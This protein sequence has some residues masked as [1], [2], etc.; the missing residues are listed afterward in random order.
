MPHAAVFIAALM[1]FGA[2]T[3]YG[4]AQGGG[5]SASAAAGAA[6]PTFVP[7]P[8]VS[9]DPV[10]PPLTVGA[11]P[12]GTPV[13][14]MATNRPT[15]SG[16]AASTAVPF[17]ASLFMGNFAALR[18]DGIN[19]AYLILPGDRVL[20]NA[21]GLVTINEV[22]I[23]DVQ[24]NIFI[25]GIGPVHLGGIP[26]GQLT[27]AVREGISRVYRNG[28]DVYTNLLSASPVAVYVTGRVVRP[29][30]YAGTPSDTPL[31]FLAQAG[32]IDAMTGSYRHV[33]V[34]RGE[35]VLADVDLYDFLISGRLP[36]VQFADGDVIL[37]DRRGPVVEV[38][39]HRDVA[40]LVEFPT[41][42]ITG[43][44]ILDVVVSAPR[45]AEITLQG[46][47]DGAQVM[48]AYPLEEFRTARLF[49]GD[50]VLL[51]NLRATGEILVHV[52]GEFHG[53][54]TL[55]V[56]RGARLLDVLAHVPTNSDLADIAGV[57]IRRT[58][59]AQ[60]Q[61][62]AL[63]D[64]LDR[65]ERSALLALSSSTGENAIRSREAEMVRAFVAT[66]R[67]VQPLGRVVASHEGLTRNVQLENEDVIVIPTRS[68]VV[69]VTGEVQVSQALAY[70]PGLTIADCVA[71]S[72]G[73]SSRAH[74]RGMLVMRPSAEVVQA[75]SSYV[76]HPGDMIIVMPHIDR[77]IL[78][79]FADVTSV[80]YQVA[81]GAATFLRLF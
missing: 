70:E 22:Y 51:N 67:T 14:S 31:F 11:L 32:G 19:A 27:A 44:D 2:P 34:L 75:S 23:V 10:S 18:E 3:T 8:P 17:G 55:A 30:R 60:N 42:T 39:G 54:A 50:A 64:S 13:P 57:H 53:P 66:A 40:E 6:N 36:N 25:P 47:R 4:H 28:Y 63:N 78:Q 29:G 16:A 9:L 59:V 72:G 58:S 74:H 5:F 52:E 77:K 37:V 65:L 15:F 33:K 24:G 76:V 38:R 79:N 62:V 41:Q 45:L 20:V 43:E 21:W 1:A 35:T 48:R 68:T 46:L 80:L 71:R 26:H 81:I 69:L 73:Y 61:R 12:P 7:S 56:S 49:D